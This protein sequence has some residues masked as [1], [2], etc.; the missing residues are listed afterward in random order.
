MKD[1]NVAVSDAD[2]ELCGDRSEKSGEENALP[3]RDLGPATAP[4]PVFF[5]ELW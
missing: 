3:H 5:Q 4:I 2:N 1:G